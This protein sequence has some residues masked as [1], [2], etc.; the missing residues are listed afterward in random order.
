MMTTPA[1][2]IF[3][4]NDRNGSR[5]SSTD[6][7]SVSPLPVEMSF[8]FDQPTSPASTIV[9]GDGDRGD[10]HNA[11]DCDFESV[12]GKLNALDLSDTDMEDSDSDSNFATDS[13]PSSPSAS[14]SEGSEGAND[15]DDID[16]DDPIPPLDD[17]E[18][19]EGEEGAAIA[20]ATASR[21]NP[22]IPPHFMSPQYETWLAAQTPNIFFT[23][24]VKPLVLGSMIAAHSIRLWYRDFASRDA[25]LQAVVDEY[26][27]LDVT[28]ISG[29][30]IKER[31]SRAWLEFGADEDSW[32]TVLDRIRNRYADENLT[33]S[34]MAVRAELKVLV[35]GQ[36]EVL[37]GKIVEKGK[38]ANGDLDDDP[39][40]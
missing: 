12:H 22:W 23:L 20:A 14:S 31:R 32:N 29:F 18:E 3:S 10:D 1:Q 25:F 33:G 13:A 24:K 38:F 8:A 5:D 26:K 7:F 30:V 11:M 36:E 34:G 39:D 9:D 6:H 2:Y 28:E 17:D 35:G 4:G 27:L 37:W 19:G 21:N 40:L 16:E 15:T